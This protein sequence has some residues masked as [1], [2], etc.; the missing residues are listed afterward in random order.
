MYRDANEI[1]AN[2]RGDYASLVRRFQAL[3][4]RAVPPHAVVAVVS[5]GDHVLLNLSGRRGWHFPQREDGVY[6]GYHPADSAAAIA[7]LEALRERGA[8]FL[9]FPATALWWLD[10][11]T[12]FKRHLETRYH[13]IARNE[14]T[15]IIYALSGPRSG[16]PRSHG[17][18]HRAR[19]DVTP[20]RRVD[21]DPARRRIRVLVGE[22]TADELQ[23]VFDADYYREQLELDLRSPDAALLHYLEEGYREEAD[24]HPLFDTRWYLDQDPDLATSDTNPLLH[25]LRHGCTECVDPNPYFDT[26]YYY[27]QR[28]RLREAQV[29]ALVHYLKHAT[30]GDS[31]RPN[32]LFQDRFYV[33]RY[34]DV[35]AEM[36]PLAH[37]LRV[38]RA[39]RRLVS[40]VHASIVRD[41][42]RASS[43]SLRRGNWKTGSVL[44]YSYGEPRDGIPDFSVL[45]EG[46]ED[47][48]RLNAIN[49]AFHRAPGRAA[50][51]RLLLLDDYR[52]ACEI[53]RPSAVRLLAKMLVAAVSPLWVI[54]EVRD[55]IEVLQGEAVGSYLILPEPAELRTRGLSERTC[56][57]AT[58]VI[59]PSSDAFN[60]AADALG[61]YPTN[62]A[63]ATDGDVRSGEGTTAYAELLLRLAERDFGFNSGAAVD[64]GAGRHRGS[65]RK[66]II[67]CADW[68]V[69]GVNAALES[70]G[71]ELLDRGWD[72]E[73]L[74]TRDEAW[75]RETVPDEGH[76]PSVPY[77]YLPRDRPGLDGMW[78]ALIAD[79][80]RNAPCILFMAY[81]FIGNSVAPAL[82]PSVGAVCW[83]QADDG[84]HYEQAY[85]LGQYC[86]TLV[87]VSERL[88]EEVTR[89]NPAIGTKSVVIQNS[90]IRESQ[91]LP[92]RGK[93]TSTMRLVYSGRLVQYQKRILD[94]RSVAEALD[95]TGV[96][97]TISL[98]GAFAAGD[99]TRN[100]FLRLCEDHLRDGRI[101]L[102]GRMLRADLLNE[103]SRNDFFLLLSDFEGFPLSVVEAMAEGCVPV[104]AESDSGITELVQT[105]MNGV[106]VSGRDYD[107]WASILC[108][109]WRDKARLS[110]LSQ[111][112][113]RTIRRR[114]TVERL[115]DRFEALF[116]QVATE[117][118]SGYERPAAL[119]LGERSRT[120][121][122]LPPPSLY[123]PA[124]V[125]VAGL[126]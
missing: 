43:D 7:H 58:R 69:S 120:G 115:A 80:E 56:R 2:G 75:V 24:P 33:N 81:D 90:S 30:K 99:E 35:P 85:R 26:E 104:I 118:R 116:E 83:V 54:S 66:I 50:S 91:I 68:G 61:H 22:H 108:A 21:P 16:A 45:A 74:F 53:L 126:R 27:S 44:L 63:L 17:K 14:D 39:E 49:V 57:A 10:H 5:K 117:V 38:G 12:E 15:G 114:F 41:V 32:P 60:S 52:L 13:D 62:V 103:L 97:Y 36:T 29:N 123:R 65:T 122:V 19:Q 92:R 82:T 20:A 101:R 86:N 18:P 4:S 124:A 37:F 96:P 95:R 1:A 46:I 88:K 34:P 125:E 11:Y 55:A 9:A 78:A 47:G 48:N 93:R 67:P 42:Q 40:Q 102:R 23:L 105:A 84:D 110:R 8:E 79:L 106:V 111:N 77:R 59:V 109:L 73:V 119:N 71:R 31:P 98:I 113:R 28:P 100:A 6:A 25:F 70:V 121:D 89:L 112:A 72:V 64:N 51:E 3:I 76:M 87:C 107:E 94:F